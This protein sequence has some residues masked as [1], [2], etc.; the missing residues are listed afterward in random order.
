MFG[1]IVA[2]FGNIVAM[3]GNIVAMFGN[4]LGMLGDV[5]FVHSCWNIARCSV[6]AIPHRP[7][8][9]LPLAY[10]APAPQLHD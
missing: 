1:N 6:E 10:S 7:P 9:R 3:F 4:I 8:L 5:R 2:M